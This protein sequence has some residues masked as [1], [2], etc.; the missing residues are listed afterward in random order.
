MYV[1]VGY[2][3]QV[4]GTFPNLYVHIHVN[5]DTTILPYYPHIYIQME[6]DV[7]KRLREDLEYYH[8]QGDP[9]TDDEFK[10]GVGE[11]SYADVEEAR[12]TKVRVEVMDAI[13]NLV[14]S[15]L[16]TFNGDRNSAMGAVLS[17]IEKLYL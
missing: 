9:A 6:K 5:K 14:N 12:Y 16:E 7:L 8:A 15:N 10:I 17:V 1:Y 11:S 2:R 4:N 3:F 13:E